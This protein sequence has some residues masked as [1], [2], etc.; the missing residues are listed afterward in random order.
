MDTGSVGAKAVVGVGNVRWRL[1]FVLLVSVLIG[2]FDRLNISLA[3]PQ[4]AKEYG[5]TVAE[6]G[7]YG[8]LL[9]SIFFVGY[10][11]ANIFLSPLGEK[12]GPRRSLITVVVLFSLFTA[13]GAPAAAA[14]SAFI[15]TRF[16]LGL[17]EG[18]HFPMMN[19]LTRNWFPA[20]ERSRANGTWAA[21]VMMSTILAS[22]LLVPVIS[23]FGWR[24]M[25][26]LLGIMGMLITV[27]LLWF[28][29]YNTPREHPSITEAEIKF[30]EAGMEEEE[31]L[32]RLSFWGQL[33]LFLSKKAYWLALLGGTLNNM[34]A[35]GLIMWLPTYF[36]EGRGL[37]F[38]DL[39][40][41]V[42][43]PY[44]ASI[45]GIALFAWLGDR[46]QRRALLT[47][48]GFVIAGTA[49]YAAATAPPVV[50]TSAIFS[51]GILAQSSY[52]ANEFAIIQ[53]I[54][55]RQRVATG[56]GLYNGLAMMIGGGLGPV[57]VGSIVAATGSYTSGILTLVGLAF[58]NAIVLFTLNRV[59]KY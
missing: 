36:T 18:I 37:D 46:T 53:R 22:V 26:V 42:S 54:V 23:A 58:V 29:C 7:E 30:I 16:L 39:Q 28:F 11:L 3:L 1:P 59:L 25:F 10:G 20:S 47:S 55:P 27:P 24:T 19:A 41:A 8:G 50:L 15:A 45:A 32:E 43:L 6:T 44:V 38:S 13:L 2:Y 34:V 4:I 35:F 51:I 49:A 52:T 5:W 12:Y 9:L 56:A 57:I 14:F 40:F 31:T 33:K 17:G 21:G 48:V